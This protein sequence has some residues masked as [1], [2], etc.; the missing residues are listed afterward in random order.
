MKT[1][2][3]KLSSLIVSI[4]VL[5]ACSG[6]NLDY[7]NRIIV[8]PKALQASSDQNTNNYS[9]S[10]TIPDQASRPIGPAD[11]SSN[12][13]EEHKA[14]KQA[15]LSI[16]WESTE[17][18]SDSGQHV[19]LLNLFLLNNTRIS[20]TTTIDWSGV[21]GEGNI[22][23]CNESNLPYEVDYYSEQSGPDYWAIGKTV[24]LINGKVHVGLDFFT[25]NQNGIISEKI[26]LNVSETELASLIV[27]EFSEN[28][29]TKYLPL[30]INEL[31]NK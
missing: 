30:W 25:W 20:T 27:K 13:I 4:F 26:L 28:G 18:I 11:A 15:N 21:N 2:E 16:Q 6:F 9:N 22:K 24:C 31:S 5:S 7:G 12:P 8:R 17:I 23:N 29:S 14:I 19:E 10:T 3:S 1:P